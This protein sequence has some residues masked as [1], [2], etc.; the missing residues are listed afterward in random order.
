M[1]VHP[2]TAIRTTISRN[3]VSRLFIRS[4]LRVFSARQM[5]GTKILR[6]MSKDY[7]SLLNH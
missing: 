7:T 1:G 2:E 6:K 5:G 3:K 4:P